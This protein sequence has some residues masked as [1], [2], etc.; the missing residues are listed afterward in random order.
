[1]YSLT[2]IKLIDVLKILESSPNYHL[3]Q[4]I[5]HQ[6][7]SEFDL[8][9]D[10][11]FFTNIFSILKFVPNKDTKAKYIF[12]VKDLLVYHLS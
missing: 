7:L 1:M 8:E 5:N 9:T 3:V 11:I 4:P 6:S 2:V 10:A 12:Y